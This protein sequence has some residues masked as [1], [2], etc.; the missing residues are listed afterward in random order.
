[1]SAITYLDQ[2]R[3]P[4]CWHTLA[5]PNRACA[6]EHSHLPRRSER[7]ARA[8]I[9]DLGA[10]ASWQA[11]E[12]DRAADARA[13]QVTLPAPDHPTGRDLRRLIE[14][15]G[16]SQ[17]ALARA[18]QIDP[19]TIRRHLAAPLV[20]RV[21]YLAAQTVLRNKSAQSCG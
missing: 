12:Q 14:A 11:W 20:P 18:L 3:C 17:Q 6:A 10:E 8:L 9:R 13:E 2:W 16:Q 1:M 5:R 21:V 19:R 4:D 15:S 7:A